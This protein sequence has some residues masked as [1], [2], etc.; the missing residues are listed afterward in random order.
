MTTN[1]EALLYIES[2]PRVCRGKWVF[3]GTRIFVSDV[4]EQLEN[5]VPRDAIVREWRGDASLDAIEEVARV[6]R[7]VLTTHRIPSA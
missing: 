3:R 5:G 6:G 1:S 2:N 4:L 7:D